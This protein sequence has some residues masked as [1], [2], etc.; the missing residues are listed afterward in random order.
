MTSSLAIGARRARSRI[1]APAALLDVVKG[2]LARLAGRNASQQPLPHLLA[3]ALE[4]RSVDPRVHRLAGDPESD[5]DGQ[6]RSLRR[7]VCAPRFPPARMTSPQV[8][9]AVS[10]LLPIPR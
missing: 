10:K 2:S 7:H 3:L 6:R 8:T 5:F 4:H 9:R 1:S